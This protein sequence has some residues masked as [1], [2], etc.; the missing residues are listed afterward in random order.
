MPDYC[1]SCGDKV[2]GRDMGEYYNFYNEELNIEIC[3]W[4]CKE[5]ALE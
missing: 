5:C 1:V 4:V 3:R 2:R